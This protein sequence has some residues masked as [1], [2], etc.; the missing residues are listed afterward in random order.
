MLV[1]QAQRG[2]PRT[3][4][5]RAEA[6]NGCA[7]YYLPGRHESLDRG[8][9][10]V[11]AARGYAVSGRTLCADF[12][13]LAFPEQ[14]ALVGQDLKARHW[15][16]AG[17][18]VGRS[19]GAYLLLHALADLPPFPGQVV[20]FAPI[21]GAVLA[22]RHGVIR[23]AI[24]PQADRLPALAR[25][26][27]FPAPASLDIYLGD[28]DGGCD[29]ELGARFAAAAAGRLHILAGV[30]H[31]IPADILAAALTLGPAPDAG[32]AVLR[33]ARGKER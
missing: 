25:S 22:D 11:L 21:L 19:Y 8:P 9:G 18:A 7:A 6:M 4:V 28:E 27:R 33:S 26:G 15:S 30:G 29:A 17:V 10:A 13:R 12:A 16:V 3:A 32:P 24:P 20:L 14:T 31:E 23:G 5:I 1:G 2:A